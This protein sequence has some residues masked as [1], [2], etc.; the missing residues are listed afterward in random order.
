M[1]NTTN[2]KEHPLPVK[3]VG[4]EDPHSHAEDVRIDHGR[5]VALLLELVPTPHSAQRPPREGDVVPQ[6]LV[7]D[8]DED[9]V[10]AHGAVGV[11]AP[12]LQHVHQHVRQPE[13]AEA[14]AA[15]NGDEAG[16]PL[17]LVDRHV[18]VEL[19]EPAQQARAQQQTRANGEVQAHAL[20]RVL[21]LAEDLGDERAEVGQQDGVHH[22]HE[23]L[24]LE[25]VPAVHVRHRRAVVDVLLAQ[26]LHVD[27]PV[28]A[29][30]AALVPPVIRHAARAGVAAR[31]VRRR[32]ELRNAPVPTREGVIGNR[33]DAEEH[34]ND[35]VEATRQ[36]RRWLLPLVHLRVV[37]VVGARVPATEHAELRVVDGREEEDKAVD[38]PRSG[39]VGEDYG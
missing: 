39:E 8:V 19:P 13:H 1:T 33:R 29:A 28:D 25:V 9:G 31:A 22:P 11:A 36:P 17:V 5:P 12:H 16:V 15:R 3:L 21:H 14:R 30:R 18:P 6:E 24:A 10:H 38:E 37:G 27:V 7:H 4:N 34:R 32:H 20:P 2:L 23:A 26:Q 35:P